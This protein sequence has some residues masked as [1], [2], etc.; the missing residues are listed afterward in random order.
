MLHLNF[1]GSRLT[2]VTITSIGTEKPIEEGKFDEGTISFKVGLRLSTY[3]YTGK[4]NG[5][6]IEGQIRLDGSTRS[7]TR[8]WNAVRMDDRNLAGAWKQTVSANGQTWETIYRFKFDAD[9]L[10]GTLSGSSG[11]EQTIED[12]EFKD[13]KITFLVHRRD[14]RGEYTVHYEGYVV[15]DSIFG[16]SKVG[17][18]SGPWKATRVKE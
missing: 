6:K 2:G 14:K 11:N 18:G 1:D 10:T 5:D 13:G 4:L 3:T 12:G 15:G 8:P 7:Q 17:G 9:K 16:Q